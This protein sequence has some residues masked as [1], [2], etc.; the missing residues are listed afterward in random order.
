VFVE[1]GAGHGRLSFQIVRQLLMLTQAWP[2]EW[3]ADMNRGQPPFLY[4]AAD[5]AE[6]NIEFL[7]QF[8]PVRSLIDAGWMDTALFDAEND[9]TLRLRSRGTTLSHRDFGG[10]LLCGVAN[11]VVDTLA[12]DAFRIRG[13]GVVEHARLSVA[14][15]ADAD[16]SDPVSLAD[17]PLSKAVD[18]L[19]ASPRTVSRAYW[20][21]T[22]KELSLSA[23]QADLHGAGHALAAEVLGRYVELLGHVEDDV[24]VILPLGGLRLLESFTVLGGGRCAFL[25]GDK[26][27]AHLDELDGCRNPHI[28]LHGSFS[29]MANLHALGIAAQVMGGTGLTTPL[30]EGFKCAA[31]LLGFG[32]SSSV[33]SPDSS[34]S[35]TAQTWRC[36]MG[37]YCPESF[38][39]IQ[40]FV[41]E[42]DSA[43]TCSLRTALSVLRLSCWEPDVAFKFRSTLVLR[44]ETASPRLRRDLV[45]DIARAVGGYYPLQPSKDIL[46]EMGRTLVN[47]S[48]YSPACVMFEDSRWWCGEHHVAWYNMGLCHHRAGRYHQAIACHLRCLELEP[49]Y[50]LSQ[51]W[52]SNART[53]LSE[54]R[55]WEER[56]TDESRKLLDAAMGE[57]TAMLARLA[58][59]PG[60]AAWSSP[61][62]LRGE[63]RP[64]EELR[65]GDR[66]MITVSVM[67]IGG[68]REQPK[69]LEDAFSEFSVE[70]G[71]EAASAELQ[72][73]RR[74]GVGQ[75]AS[76]AAG[77][78]YPVGVAPA[79]ASGRDVSVTHVRVPVDASLRDV[80]E[81]TES[82]ATETQSAPALVGRDAAIESIDA[83]ALL[84]E[85]AALDG[86]SDSVE[87]EIVNAAAEKAASARLLAADSMAIKGDGPGTVKCMLDCVQSALCGAPDVRVWLTCVLDTAYT[88][89]LVSRVAGGD[90]PK[91]PWG[92]LPEGV[93][94]EPS[95]VADR[96]LAVD[97]AVALGA[98]VAFDSRLAKPPGFNLILVKDI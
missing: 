97:P 67:C 50:A 94:V 98:R 5:L 57:S 41:S 91:M 44:A 75:F 63:V 62:E 48:R 71:L 29:F 66:T 37:R 32:G 52:L 79:W 93:T 16:G 96:V 68:W 42:L 90:V 13:G 20:K 80:L 2:P 22:W 77:M 4:V 54:R 23:A 89:S 14:A 46:F 1:V 72:A 95:C 7:E 81:Q 49:T 19:L 55:G 25:V 92:D 45:A 51:T 56:L 10:R 24:S 18:R 84:L 35:E 11:Y 31:I 78:R 64:A 87:R 53:R 58:V 82:A 36:E 86:E 33:S 43:E 26:A 34:T 65:G 6:K 61:E 12:Q 76:W 70:S 73:I 8:F 88:A 15:P 17:E 28:A 27:Y 69:G 9:R 3:V 60:D 47:I 39:A 21:W 59:V 74:G 83:S 30:H 38:S 85:Q 40:R